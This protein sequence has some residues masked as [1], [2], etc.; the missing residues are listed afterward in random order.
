MSRVVAVIVAR[1]DYRAEEKKR[2]GFV[3]GTCDRCK[4]DILI[5][6]VV[7]RDIVPSTR[8]LCIECAS[9]TM[10]TRFGSSAV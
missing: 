2:H 5:K 10:V 8:V 9:E 3:V 1:V 6:E 7:H 4:H